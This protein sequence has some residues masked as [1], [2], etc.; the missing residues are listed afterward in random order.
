MVTV[1][2]R[3]AVCAVVVIS[4]TSC[5]ITGNDTLVE[6][7]ADQIDLRPAR[8]FDKFPLY[9]LGR[10]YRGFPLTDDGRWEIR[11]YARGAKSEPVFFAYGPCEPAPDS[12]ESACNPPV[13]MATFP[14]CA[15]PLSQYRRK[16]SQH[17]GVP[18]LDR[19]T[20]V[21]VFTGRVTVVIQTEPPY[22]AIDAVDAMRS[23]N[24]ARPIRPKDDLPRPKPSA[25]RKNAKPC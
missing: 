15:L 23:L 18:F 20:R 9:Y 16:L 5:T 24:L 10:S 22:H 21:E 12:E 8:Q 13:S 14:A 4:L 7:R 1:V 2:M 25:H 17:R 19:G 6:K 3:L 11:A